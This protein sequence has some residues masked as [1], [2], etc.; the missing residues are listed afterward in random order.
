ML[1][2]IIQLAA[3]CRS[4]DLRVSTSEV[5]DCAEQLTLVNHSCEPDVKTVINA[6]FVK[7]RRDQKKFDQIYNLFFHGIPVNQSFTSKAAIAPGLKDPNI[8]DPNLDNMINDL[9]KEGMN[10][11]EEQALI[12]FLQGKP[13]SFLKTILDLHTR[14]EKK[15]GP[16]KSNL[17]QLTNKLAM[18]LTISQIKRKALAYIK[19]KD[20]GTQDRDNFERHVNT[21]L[22]EAG[23]L[24]STEAGFYNDAVKENKQSIAENDSLLQTPFASLT[25]Q[26][27]QQMK[28]L[29]DQLVRKLQNQV[30]RR[31]AS[32]NKGA[33]DV[34]KTLRQ[35]GKYQGIPIRLSFKN[36]P[37]KKTNI[38]TLCDVSGSVWSTAKFMLH[39]LY[40]L[41]D[42]FAKVR[43][44]VFVSQLAEVTHFFDTHN[45]NQAVKM[46]MEKANINYNDQT[47]YGNAFQTVKQSYPDLLNHKTTLI[48][49]GDGR[50]N[51]LNPQANI[52]AQFRE[53]TRRI[54][55]LNPEPANTWYTGDS[56]IRNYRK[57]C[58]EI[59]TCMNMAHLN[60]V[61][62]KLAV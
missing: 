4:W 10:R 37:K 38:V 62:K 47:D 43:S 41:Q 33:L 26:D 53:K 39:F 14:E 16:Y 32:K 31:L 46:A 36:K 56:E 3:C 25:A 45:V 40:S 7:S 28:Q 48:I 24:L 49:L 2:T 11:P 22:G 58:H 23:K 55:W 19:S 50:S 1:R 29:I 13:A 30:S 9:K 52:L 15:P 8:E 20:L 44:F 5:I 42:C 61:I 60:T 34:K 27:I 59:C 18:M 17:D 51:Y 35:A 54:L 6:N 21:S 57:H 12:E